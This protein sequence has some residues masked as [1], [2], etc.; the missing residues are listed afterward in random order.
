MKPSQKKAVFLD[1]D[2]VINR[3]V[4]FGGNPFPPSKLK[5]VE[6]LQGVPEA[7]KGLKNAG[8]LLVCVTNQPDVARGKQSRKIVEAIHRFLLE[9]LPLDEIVV[10]YHDDSDACR[11][12]KPLPGMLI[13]AAK[14]YSINLG[15]SFMVGDRW[16]DIEAGRNA[17]C[18]TILIDYDYE[19]KRPETYDYLVKTLF[20]AAT[21]IINYLGGD[22]HETD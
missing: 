12:R 3:C 1:R 4:M 21:L 20:E 9:S 7:L 22:T 18:R 11:C 8:F 14:R 17:G 19:E 2:G 6:I 5:D 16:R 10:C 15:D 13:D